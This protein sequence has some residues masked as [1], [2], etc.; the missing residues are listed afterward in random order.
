MGCQVRGWG[1]ALPRLLSQAPP[2]PPPVLTRMH[3][4]PPTTP[5]L[6]L[7]LLPSAAGPSS[8]AT[9]LAQGRPLRLMRLTKQDVSKQ[10]ENTWYSTAQHTSRPPACSGSPHPIPPT[11]T[12]AHI[13]ARNPL[14]RRLAPVLEALCLLPSLSPTLRDECLAHARALLL[15]QGAM[16]PAERGN[17][18]RVGA[19][20]VPCPL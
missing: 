4:P 1:W 6:P 7:H 17:D 8:T 2:P 20:P 5:A 15:Q 12:H 16:A 10:E 3:S 11:H 13:Q 19:L 9:A 14:A 18:S